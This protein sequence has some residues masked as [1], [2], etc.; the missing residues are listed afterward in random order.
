M[1]ARWKVGVLTVSDRA[2]AKTIEDKSGPAIVEYVEK[3]LKDAKVVKTEIVP[4]EKED[5]KN[6]LISWSSEKIN[7]IITT[8]GTGFAPRDITPEATKEI[9]EKEA[10][11]IVTAMLLASLKVTPHAI[12]SRP[13]A[14]SRGSSLIINLPGSPKAVAECLEPLIP[15]LPHALGLL[16]SDSEEGKTPSHHRLDKK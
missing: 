5:I 3:N 16:A 2:S 12:L 7:L 10:P 6:M 15:A 11:G 4:D 14:G 8:G 9:L 1:E 13:A